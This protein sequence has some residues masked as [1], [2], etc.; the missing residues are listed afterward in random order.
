MVFTVVITFIDEDCIRKLT[1]PWL[2]FK[3]P[4]WIDQIILFLW[5]KEPNVASSNSSRSG[6]SPDGIRKL[7]KEDWFE[8]LKLNLMQMYLQYLQ[9]LGLCLVQMGNK[10]LLAI[11]DMKDVLKRVDLVKFQAVE[12]LILN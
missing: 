6:D 7:E 2:F 10:R 4:M 9:T 8:E 12:E 5:Q 1:Y 3:Q 11:S